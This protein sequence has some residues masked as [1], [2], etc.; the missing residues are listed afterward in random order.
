V[1][2][3]NDIIFSLIGSSKE[4]PIDFD[5]AWVWIGYTRKDNAKS[6]LLSAGF[7]DGTDF[8]ILLNNQENSKV[9]RPSDKIMLTIDC[10]KSF[11]M[12][13]GTSKGHQVRKYFLDCEQELKRRIEE[14]KKTYRER[15]V[16]IVVDGQPTTWEKRFQDDFFEEAYRITGWQKTSKG[17]PSCMGHFINNNVYNLFP[18]GVV[19][20]LKEVNPLNSSGSRSRKHH[21]HLTQDIGLPLLDYQKGVTIAVMRLSPSGST[22]KFKQNMKKA[23]GTV[24][25][26]EMPFMEEFEVD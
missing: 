20:K 17:H 16:N 10:F 13:A 12:M 18:E 23:C 11:C 5:N 8:E 14:E 22:K 15:V 6:S 25:Q 26:V 2:L 7:I 19:E 24:L 9:G 21:Q 1:D 4:F 3:D